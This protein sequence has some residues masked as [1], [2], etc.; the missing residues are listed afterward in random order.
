MDVVG[1]HETGDRDRPEELVGR[2]RARLV[3]R[4]AG[5]REEVLHD[6]FLHVAVAAVRCRDRL[7]RLDAFGARLADADEDP[8]GERDAGASGGVERGQPALGC[9]VG[10]TGVRAAVVA[11]P[12][13]Q[14]LDHHPLRRADRPE[15]FEL[16]LR[17]RTRVGVGEQTGFLEHEAGDVGE[18]VD[19]RGVPGRGEPLGRRGIPH[20][21]LFAEGEERFGATELCALPRDREHFF[22]GQVRGVEPGR[23]LGEGAVA[24][25]VT[26]QH[27]ERDE[28]LGRVGDAAAE[29][30][31]TSRRGGDHELLER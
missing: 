20:F 6:H 10:C 31:V 5:L 2:A 30:R 8:G 12:S 28:H 3:H 23:R 15:L 18:V 11:E 27:R 13:G 7:E 14:R 25:P 9:L 29:G 17:E 4:R 19:R 16:G 24:A 21:R 22:R 1:E 26:A